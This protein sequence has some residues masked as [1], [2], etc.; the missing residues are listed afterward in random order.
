LPRC[1]R[2]QGRVMP[3]PYYLAPA[4][5]P[6]ITLWVCGLEAWVPAAHRVKLIGGLSLALYVAGLLALVNSELPA[7]LQ[8]LGIVP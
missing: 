8:S 1:D 3:A 7:Y 6:L 5:V 4:S 2:Y